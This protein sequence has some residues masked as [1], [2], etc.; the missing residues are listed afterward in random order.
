[1]VSQVKAKNEYWIESNW[2]Q[3]KKWPDHKQNR[4]QIDKL[5]TCWRLESVQPLDT[6]IVVSLD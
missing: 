6:V 1:M 4:L 3:L 2:E 5:A